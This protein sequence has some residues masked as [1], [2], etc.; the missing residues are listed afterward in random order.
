LLE[1]GSQWPQVI[2]VDNILHI[3]TNDTY[4]STKHRVYAKRGCMNATIFQHGSI[5]GLVKILLELL[6][7]GEVPRYKSNP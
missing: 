6:K 4:K 1:Q 5:D 3:L 7:G 2:D